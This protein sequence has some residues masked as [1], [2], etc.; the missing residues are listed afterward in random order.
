VYFFLF[1]LLSCVRPR[2]ARLARLLE[3]LSTTLAFT[4]TLYLLVL[5]SPSLPYLGQHS[6]LAA[7]MLATAGRRI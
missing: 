4:L 5:L 1:P 6:H 7:S 3:P 2:L